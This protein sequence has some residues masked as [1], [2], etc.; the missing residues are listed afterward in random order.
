MLELNEENH[1]PVYLEQCKYRSKKKKLVGFINAELKNSSDDDDDGDHADDDNT[2]FN[3]FQCVLIG[4][5]R[6]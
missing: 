2:N 6:F 3:W 1:P 5:Y 4:I